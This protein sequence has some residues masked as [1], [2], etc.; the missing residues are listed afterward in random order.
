[1][2]QRFLQIG[3][4]LVGK[5]YRFYPIH[6]Q[7]N[8][9][10]KRN[11]WFIRASHQPKPKEEYHCLLYIPKEDFGFADMQGIR[12]NPDLQN[13]PIY[14][15]ERSYLA[16]P[17]FA[18]DFD[19]LEELIQEA[20]TTDDPWF[21]TTSDIKFAW[22]T[23]I[24]LNFLEPEL[25]RNFC[26]S[27]LEKQLQGLIISGDIAESHDLHTHLMELAMMLPF[28]IYFI[29]GNHDFYGNSVTNVTQE[30]Q[31]LC[32]DYKNLIWLTDAEAIPFGSEVCLLGHDGW[33][34]GRYGDFFHSSVVMNDYLLIQDFQEF[35]L[36]KRDMKNVFQKLNELGDRATAQVQIKLKKALDQ[37]RRV[38]FVTHVPPFAEASIYHGRFSEP[39]WLPHFACKAMGEML[40]TSMRQYPQSQLLVLCGHTHGMGAIRIQDNILALTGDAEYGSPIIQYIFQIA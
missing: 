10:C 5:D 12:R 3:S 30:I 25:S 31:K 38:I 40:I 29:L 8:M 11:G 7:E 1:M 27:I 28:P 17:Y 21:S 35:F 18:A 33:A 15:L 24:H 32:Q 26:T 13:M 23:D 14:A 22:V 6:A 19:H 16:L 37:Y 20:R 34:D 9:I 36:H 4:Q 39:E 2:D